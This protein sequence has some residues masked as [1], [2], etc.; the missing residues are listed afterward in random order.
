MAILGQFPS[1]LIFTIGIL[2]PVRW[3]IAHPLSRLRNRKTSRAKPRKH[4]TLKGDFSQK[5]LTE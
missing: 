4:K 3:T 2:R 5:N 1:N